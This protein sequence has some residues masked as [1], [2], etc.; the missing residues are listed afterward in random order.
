MKKTGKII[1]IVIVLALAGGVFYLNLLMPIIT[2]YAA[3]NLASAVF[4][5]GRTQESVEN[6]NL[7]FSF[8]KFTKNTIDYDKKVVV[9]RF[10]WSKSTALFTEDYGCS[11]IK[12]IDAETYK[13]KL[14]KID[15]SLSYDPDTVAWPMGNV[16][17][18][19]IPL[20]V[21][22]EKIT[23]LSDM[24][25][26]DTGRMNGTFAL[27]VVY[28][29]VPIVERYRDDFDENTRF[30]SWSMAKSLTSTLVGLRADEQKLDINAPLSIEEWQDD[31]RKH[32]TLKNLLQ[33]N[34]GLEWN[35]G[36]GSL[37]DVTVMLHKVS[38]F[39]HYTID[40]PLADPI[41][42]KYLYSSG[43]TNIVSYLLRQSFEKDSQYYVYPYDKLFKKIGI[44]NAI[45]E[46][47]NVGTYVGSS[48]WYCTMRD[49]ARYGL[50][51]ARKGYFAGKQILS[52]E[53]IDFTDEP[54]EGSDNGY[55]AFFRINKGKSF[56]NAPE[57][58][59]SCRGHNGQAIFIIP[60]MDVVIVRTGYSPHQS[61]DFG[62]MVDGVL[63]C[64]Q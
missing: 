6:E 54:A 46:T 27:M 26:S 17:P 39:A 16:M 5:S 33:M 45:F 35:E 38:N 48:Y 36:Y 19:S 30:L 32:I 51:Y 47:D 50:L 24:V 3:K 7:N 14:P 28:K 49:Y 56:S 64:V 57:D 23:K 20:G 15:R 8:I 55:T 41:E 31:D 34:S 63:E 25:F 61:F 9:S 43:T 59:L 12:D 1:L 37:S 58:M 62:K 53:W 29:G 52:K 44:N 60:S 40:K 42:K 11:L 21:D 18:D 2:G 13:S 22:M 10:L 4:V